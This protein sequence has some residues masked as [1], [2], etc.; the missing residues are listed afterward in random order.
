MALNEAEIGILI[1]QRGRILQANKLLDFC[2]TG[3]VNRE[4]VLAMMNEATG[5]LDLALTT[6]RSQ[7]E[8]LADKWG[9]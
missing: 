1:A 2:A 8:H 5:K 4:I 3:P 9:M 6:L 7:R